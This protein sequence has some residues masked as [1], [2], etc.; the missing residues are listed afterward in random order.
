MQPKSSH[1]ESINLIEQLLS[2]KTG[3]VLSLCAEAYDIIMASSD[4]A[5]A[6]AY[7]CQADFPEQSDGKI[8]V[9]ER[10]TQEQKEDF[11]KRKGSLVDGIFDAILQENYDEAVFYQT[12]WDKIS[13]ETLLPGA[14][15]KIFALYYIWIDN[16]VPYFKLDEKKALSKTDAQALIGKLIVE[17]KKARFILCSKSI[18]N[19]TKASYLVDMMNRM[20]SENDQAV[21]MAS[22]WSLVIQLVEKDDDIEAVDG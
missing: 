13:Q 19:L 7:F 5:V 4:S 14:D 11:I 6:F 21:F 15:E 2:S 1:E 8:P 16:R 3:D 18:D 9:I 17:L 20:E 22:V 12:L 10:Y